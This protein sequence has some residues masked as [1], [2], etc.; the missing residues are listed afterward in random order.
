[1]NKSSL[2]IAVAAA[3]FASLDAAAVSVAANGRGQALVFP[4]YTVEAGQTTLLSLTNHTDRSKALIVNFRESLNGR[5]VMSFN[6][7]LGKRDVWTAGVF[8]LAQN[9]PANLTTADRSCT[10]PGIVSSVAVSLPTLPNGQRY[11]PFRNFG[12][13]GTGSGV[14]ANADGGPTQLTRTRTGFVEIIE[15]ATL[16]PDSPSDMSANLP[17][18]TGC[19]NLEAAWAPVGYWSAN[20]V[21]DLAAPTGGLSG[22]VQLVDIADG[23]LAGTGATALA[24][25]NNT[26]AHPRP[27][28]GEA[29]GVPQPGT[30]GSART[31]ATTARSVVTTDSGVVKSSNWPVAQGYKAVSAALAKASAGQEFLVTAGIGGLSDWVLTFPTRRYHT[32]PAL[33]AAA[34]APFTTRFVANS[35]SP[36][37]TCESVPSRV[38]DRDRNSVPSQSLNLCGSVQV[39]SFGT[40]SGASAVVGA[41]NPQRVDTGMLSE[42]FAELDFSGF[43]STAALGGETWTG[44][45]VI[46]AWFYRYSN[47]EAQPGQLGLYSGSAPLTGTTSCTGEGC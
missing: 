37:I 36:A 20:A 5:Q 26:I 41:P 7:Y 24:Q 4:F 8:S 39:L 15:V 12:F 47:S 27:G 29:A 31:D 14:G 18:G 22:S 1:M 32:D 46:G 10:V 16:V 11:V 23:A 25:F 19:P 44:L 42:G 30:L 45:P 35:V 17:N 40:S 33:T 43:T 6:L 38:Y 13:V 21:T 28:E 34:V 3:L 2:S 9:G